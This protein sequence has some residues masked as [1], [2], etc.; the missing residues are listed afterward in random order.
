M[1]KMKF[2]EVKRNEIKVSS[3]IDDAGDFLIRINGTIIAFLDSDF[4]TLSMVPLTLIE[5]KKLEELGFEFDGDNL[6]AVR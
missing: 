3:E 1:S 2:T 4:G 6:L 5:V